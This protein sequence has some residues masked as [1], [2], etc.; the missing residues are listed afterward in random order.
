MLFTLKKSRGE[1]IW[2][3]DFFVPNEARYRAA[4]HPEITGTLYAAL[5][6]SPNHFLDAHAVKLGRYRFR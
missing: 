1:R 5:C 6:D 4:L 3:S 2:T